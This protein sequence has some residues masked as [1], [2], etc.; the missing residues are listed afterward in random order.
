MLGGLNKY[1]GFAKKIFPS[2]SGLGQK[3]MT[4]EHI[5]QMSL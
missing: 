3:A 4:L 5:A 1:S 2:L